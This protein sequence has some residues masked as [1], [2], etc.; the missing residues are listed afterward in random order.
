[1]VFSAYSFPFFVVDQVNGIK[2]SIFANQDDVGNFTLQSSVYQ[3][4]AW[5]TPIVIS[6][7][8]RNLVLAEGDG[9]QIA[10]NKFGQCF[11]C[12]ANYDSGL[13]INIL[14]ARTYS[15]CQGWGPLIELTDNTMDVQGTGDEEI[16][17]DDF[18]NMSVIYSSLNATFDQCIYASTASFAFSPTWS[19]PVVIAQG[20]AS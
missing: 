13:A 11:A 14:E 12:W 4:G 7:P 1:M 16:Y 15:F 8:S 10:I 2:I 9:I 17:I 19:A 3:D 5:S 18:G 6:D 20:S